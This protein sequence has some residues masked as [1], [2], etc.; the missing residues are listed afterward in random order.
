MAA[1][2]AVRKP[3][4]PGCAS[5]EAKARGFAPFSFDPA[6]SG[7]DTT[8]ERARS[9][10]DVV[11][12]QLRVAVA[13]LQ[14]TRCERRTR[15]AAVGCWLRA[16]VRRASGRASEGCCGSGRRFCR[17][18]APLSTPLRS[19]C[20][21]RYLVLGHLTSLRGMLAGAPCWSRQR[22]TRLELGWALQPRE[23]RST[24]AQLRVGIPPGVTDATHSRKPLRG[25]CKP[26]AFDP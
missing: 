18:F 21:A 12:L 6:G 7:Q 20:P 8:L 1:P 19:N 24:A 11:R 5:G 3:D 10:G 13:A 16:R 26:F 23:S 25:L 14:A 17:G 4:E 2:A 9:H 15:A 22:S